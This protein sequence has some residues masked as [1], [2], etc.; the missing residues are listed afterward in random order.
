MTPDSFSRAIND[1][2][3]FSS[4]E[5]ARIATELDTDVYWLITGQPDPNKLVFAARHDYDQESR[6]HS[7]PSEV[8]DSTVLEDIHVAYRQAF[9]DDGTPQ[10]IPATAENV[11][12]SLGED[13]VRPLI[14]RIENKLGVDVIR[15]PELA[16][17]YSFASAGRLVIAIQATG[18]WFRENWG[19]AHELAH[20][21]GHRSE[22][23]AN[24]FAAN[25]L[26]PERTL[27]EVEWSA[28][29]PRE[30][31]RFVWDTGISTDA[32]QRRLRKLN[33]QLPHVI[34]HALDLPTQAL[35]RQHWNHDSLTPDA[36]AERMENASARRFPRSLIEAHQEAI[37]E[38]RISVAFLAWM[39]GVGASTLEVA[40]PTTDEGDSD[41][42]DELAALLGLI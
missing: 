7:L 37:A 29:D 26:L 33:I 42:A 35:L 23:S 18:N 38:G 30:L 8:A 11:R 24:A 2:R 27:R 16:T 6:L 31:A 3:A 19:L 36:I 40:E 10:S 21:A 41:K 9:L 15:L 22:P 13:F 39:L 28:I 14:E 20:L 32:L 25:L 17:A 5:L 4:V 34:E 1:K 12:A